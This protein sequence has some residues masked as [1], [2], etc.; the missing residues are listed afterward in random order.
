[1]FHVRRLPVFIVIL[2]I[3]YI[4]CPRNVF[5]CLGTLTHVQHNKVMTNE[6]HNITTINEYINLYGYTCSIILYYCV[7]KT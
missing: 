1:M 3:L 6:R 7:L 5:I 2:F 4:Y